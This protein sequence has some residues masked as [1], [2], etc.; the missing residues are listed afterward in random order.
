MPPGFEKLDLRL[1]SRLEAKGEQ[2]K[3]DR[4][5]SVQLFATAFRCQGTF[6][7]AF[8]FQFNLL[9][10]GTVAD[11][12]HVDVD[13]DSQREFDASN[14]I[15]IRYEGK[16]SEFLQRLELG[17]VSFAPPASRFITSGIPAG[18]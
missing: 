4:C 13:Y 12:V 9:T 16:Q 2:V 18:N 11:R 14:K 17:N 7:P 15:S 10:K 1:N 6:Q 5:G 8:D 3:N